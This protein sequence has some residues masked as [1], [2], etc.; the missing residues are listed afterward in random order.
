M[1]WDCRGVEVKE[2]VH[3]PDLRILAFRKPSGKLTIV[4][5]NR[6]FT[7]HTF[8]VASGLRNATFKGIRYTPDQA[9]KDCMGVEIGTL[10]GGTLAPEVP[11]M[12]WE[13]WE[14]QD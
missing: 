10:Q 7:A 13:F 14:Q 9:G 2:A 4:L 3:D 1:P 5:A 6:S 11:D 12:T 8:K